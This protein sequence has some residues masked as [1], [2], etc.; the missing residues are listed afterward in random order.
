MSKKKDALL[1]KEPVMVYH[2][3]SSEDTVFG[4]QLR[5]KCPDGITRVIHACYIRVLM[6]Y[7]NKGFMT[8]AKRSWVRVGTYCPYCGYIPNVQFKPKSQI[9]EGH[10]V[11]KSQP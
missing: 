3:P 10:N 4:R 6:S 8:V 1:D 7:H 5:H 9:K 11:K 2:K